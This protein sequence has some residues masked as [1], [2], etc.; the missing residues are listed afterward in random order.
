MQGDEHDGWTWS[1]EHV[2]GRWKTA[3]WQTGSGSGWWM[4]TNDQTP[5]DIK[6]PVGGFEINSTERPRTSETSGT[7]ETSASATSSTS[8]ASKSCWRR[9]R[10]P[11]PMASPT[12]KPTRSPSEGS[13]T[14]EWSEMSVSF[15][16]KLDEEF[17]RDEAVVCI[18]D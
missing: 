18:A 13:A 7:S 10:T 2:D 17:L 1:G 14:S 8:G 3:D 16:G 6:E 4:T 9:R 15:G 11:T 5:W 12:L